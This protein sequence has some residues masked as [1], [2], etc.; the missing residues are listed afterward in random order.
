MGILQLCPE[1]G[2]LGF[3]AI[4]LVSRQLSRLEGIA[5]K[6][7][8]RE[9]IA[10]GVDFSGEP[11]YNFKPLLRPSCKV[12]RDDYRTEVSNPKIAPH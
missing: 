1:L 4:K 12:W 5:F 10:E 8:L 7:K 6:L 11:V 2:I 9:A 3:E